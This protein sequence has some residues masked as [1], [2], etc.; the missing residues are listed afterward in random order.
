MHKEA[1]EEL[2]LR[3][4]LL[5]LERATI[6]N[7]DPEITRADRFGMEID[8]YAYNDLNSFHGWV[9]KYGEPLHWVSAEIG[10]GFVGFG[11]S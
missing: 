1:K 4:K 5:V 8:F 3:F 6:I 11:F 10:E 9:I 2:T 7:D